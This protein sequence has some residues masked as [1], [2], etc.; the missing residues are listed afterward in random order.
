M[1]LESRAIMRADFDINSNNASPSDCLEEGG[2]K[3]EAATVRDSRFDDYIRL[4]LID[5]RLQSYHVV[6]DLN[7]RTA[8]PRESVEIFLVPSNFEPHLRQEAKTLF[9]VEWNFFS[10][11]MNDDVPFRVDLHAGSLA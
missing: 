4:E 7:N 8:K 6:G 1:C 3:D 11:L 10:I 5:N 9:R 2:I